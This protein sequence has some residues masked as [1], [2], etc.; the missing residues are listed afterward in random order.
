MILMW[1][2]CCVVCNVN[3]GMIPCI[4]ASKKILENMVTD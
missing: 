3:D 4:L 2:W 1:L